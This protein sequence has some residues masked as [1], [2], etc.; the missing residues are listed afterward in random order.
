MG[1]VDIGDHLVYVRL[2]TQALGDRGEIRLGLKDR[3]NLI[4]WKAILNRSEEDY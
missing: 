1:A 2:D 4:T 3:G